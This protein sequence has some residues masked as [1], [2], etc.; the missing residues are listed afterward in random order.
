MEMTAFKIPWKNWIFSAN[1]SKI[2]TYYTDKNEYSRDYIPDEL[3]AYE[4][5]DSRGVA[6]VRISMRNVQNSPVSEF[7]GL[8]L[9]SA[10]AVA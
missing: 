6:M 3:K 2:I 10:A 1:G 5:N 8:F 9:S 4:K 7:F